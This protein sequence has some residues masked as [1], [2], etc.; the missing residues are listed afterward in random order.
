MAKA[1]WV[2]KAARFERQFVDERQIA[3]PAPQQIFQLPHGIAVG[4]AQFGECGIKVRGD[5][6]PRGFSFAIFVHGGGFLF[7]GSAAH[8]GA[9]G[10]RGD[11]PCGAMQPAGQHRM[12]REFPG[13][14][15]QRDEHALRHVLGEMWIIHHPDCGGVHEIDVPAHQL[16]EGGFGA[17]FGVGSQQLRVGQG[18]HLPKSSR[19]IWNR[20]GKG[21]NPGRV[22]DCALLPP[23]GPQAPG[24]WWGSSFRLAAFGF[25][26]F[27]LVLM[28]TRRGLF[29]LLRVGGG[30]SL[31]EGFD[32]LVL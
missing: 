19:R 15:R 11:V 21:M 32:L 4:L 8:L 9:D 7:T 2:G 18:V 28:G 25:R 5:F 3:R 27:T 20:T 29:E 17:A 13:I 24:S 6:L 22:M 14:L 26:G 31:E 23:A 10:L 12:V 1:S 16:G 30:L